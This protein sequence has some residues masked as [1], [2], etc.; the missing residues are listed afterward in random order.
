MFASRLGL[1]WCLFY[2]IYCCL[3]VDDCLLCMIVSFGLVYLILFL[4]VCLIIYF[5]FDCLG[6]IGD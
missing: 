4:F 2:L 6:C 1:F 5:D 3:L